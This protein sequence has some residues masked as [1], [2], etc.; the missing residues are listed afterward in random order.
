MLSPLISPL[1]DTLDLF[2][3]KNIPAL[4]LPANHQQEV[5]QDIRDIE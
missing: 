3:F 1:A 5:Q 4:F 2:L